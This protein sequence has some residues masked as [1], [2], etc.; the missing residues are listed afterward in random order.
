VATTLTP[1]TLIIIKK[2][3]IKKQISISSAKLFHHNNHLTLLQYSQNKKERNI[4]K[5]KKKR[6]EKKINKEEQIQYARYLYYYFSF[7][8]TLPHI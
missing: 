7:N 3:Y 6:K 8:V 2:M 4:T 5:T 1:M